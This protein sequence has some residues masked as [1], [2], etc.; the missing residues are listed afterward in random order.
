MED[1][2]KSVLITGGS[3]AAGAAACERF[4]SAGWTVFLAGS[5]PAVFAAAER[6]GRDR[7]GKC[8]PLLFDPVDAQ[9][10]VPE[11]FREIGRAGCVPDALVCAHCV[12]GGRLPATDLDLKDWEALL[13]TNV[14]A[15]YMAARC[16]A[17]AMIAAGKQGSVVFVGESCY[18]SAIPGHCALVSSMGA[19]RSL[20]RGLALDFAP[21]G[22]RVN[23]VM[24]GPGSDPA[25]PGIVNAVW[26]FASGQAG[27]ATGS[28]LT[29][30][31]GADCL[32]PGAY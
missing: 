13:K 32:V 22:I 10:S 1:R 14:F 26:F 4:L 23:C 19:L 11:L 6:F 8:R 7:P 9:T 2:G 15:C 5:D 29:V 27:E 12:R 24:A 25:G 20:A 17:Q 30:D 31:G 18:K 21:H 28:A 3:E 16:A